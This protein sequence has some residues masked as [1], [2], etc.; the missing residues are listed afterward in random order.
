M[1]F[2]SNRL[3]LYCAFILFRILIVL[4]H[5]E[6]NWIFVSPSEFSHQKMGKFSVDYTFQH[7]K[8]KENN[9]PK[10]KWKSL[11]YPFQ[12]LGCWTKTFY[13]LIL[14]CRIYNFTL[15]CSLKQAKFTK[16]A[17]FCGFCH[18]CMIWSLSEYKLFYVIP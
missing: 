4:D 17:D 12:A 1:I 3:K 9:F 14:V 15:R 7:C 5:D 2:P 6:K 10:E 11:D 13:T 16:Y 8:F 18:F